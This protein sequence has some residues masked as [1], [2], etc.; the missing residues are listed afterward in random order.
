MGQAEDVSD[1]LSAM[2]QRYPNR[3]FLVEMLAE[4]F[5]DMEK[6]PQAIAQYNK[7][8]TSPITLPAIK[9]SI[10]LNNLGYL[11]TQTAQYALAIEHA[12]QAVML[13]DDIPIFYDT[14][15][16]ALSKSG[17][18]SKARTYLEKALSMAAVSIEIQ[19]HLAYTIEKIEG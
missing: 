19:A 4:H 18:Y 16:W 8:L 10:A 9:K 14:L 17:E 7:L 2:H 3:M 13:R 1:L 5:M 6:Y 11:Y 12:Q 15:G